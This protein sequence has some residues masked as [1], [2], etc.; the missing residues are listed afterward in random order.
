MLRRRDLPL[1]ALRGFEAAARQKSMAR[2]ADELGVTYSA[3]SHQIRKLEDVLGASLF[4]R[5]H[6]PLSLTS[7]GH[8]LLMSVTDSFDRLSRAAEAVGDT[9]LEGDLMVSCV[10]GLGTNW[11]VHALGEFLHS[12]AKLN[13]HVVT[14]FWHHPAS[15][16]EVD[17][18]ITYGSAEHAGRRVV[19]LGQSEFFPVCS[20]RIIDGL[21]RPDN[22]EGMTL[23]HDHSEET[24]SRWLLESGFKDIVDHRNIYFDSAHLAL[25]AARTGHG[26]AMGDRP[27]IQRDLSEG[28]LLRLFDQSVPAIHPYYIVTPPLK[29]MKPAARALEAWI[30]ERF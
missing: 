16:D 5:R 7:T 9:G 15:H 1:Y 22:L 12:Y 6:K 26:V 18:A 19:R 23:L 21:S 8:A 10:P 24:W 13:V 4:D 30:V 28:R 2:A 20:P 29:H 3:I 11:F 14:E 17:L 25:E 27:T